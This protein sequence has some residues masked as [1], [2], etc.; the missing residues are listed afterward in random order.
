MTKNAIIYTRVS[1][2]EQAEGGYSLPSQEKA[3]RKFAKDNGYNVVDVFEERGE[4]AKTVNRTEFQ[5]MIKYALANKKVIDAII[6]V[7]FDRFSRDLE[8][9]ISLMKNFKKHNIEILSTSENNEDS[10][11]GNLMRNIIGSFSQYE[12]DVKSVRVKEGMKE[13]YL[14][15]KWLW[16]APIGYLYQY[17]KL[18]KNPKTAPVIKEIF[19]LFS[20]GMYQQTELIKF[21]SEKGIKIPAV[22]MSKMLRNTFYIGY[23][24]LKKEWSEVPIRGNFEPIVDEIIF[25]KVQRILE[26]KK[27]LITAYKRNNPDFPL[28]QF[29]TCPNCNSG[30]TGSWSKNNRGKRYPNYRCYRKCAISYNINRDRLE[31]AFVDYLKQIK[32]APQFLK[33]FKETIKQVFNDKT[34]EEKLRLN[35]QIK[36][37]EEIKERKSKLIDFKLEGSISQDDYMFKSEQLTAQINEIEAAMDENKY[38]NTNIDKCLDYTC[39]MIANLDDVWLDANLDIKQRL[40]KLI[41]PKGLAY[42]VDKFR[43]PEISS[44]FKIIGTLSVPSY[45]MVPPSEFESLSTP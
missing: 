36:Q 5:K 37:L 7:R 40:Q 44:L 9:Q 11:T 28:R 33:L 31:T 26:G 10:P 6:V 1:T 39:N 22:S 23:L 42:E 27:P 19:E 41:F 34:K 35:K 20:T 13:A 2:K 4:S 32:P 16:R 14:Q 38:A 12:N 18:V 24:P 8:D 15:G 21:A 29:I 30:L 3:C 43:T 25:K 17:E 45:N